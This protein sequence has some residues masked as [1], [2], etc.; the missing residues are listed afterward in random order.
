MA[1]EPYY[2][3]RS[4]GALFIFFSWILHELYIKPRSPCSPGSL[5]L[6]LFSLAFPVFFLPVLSSFSTSPF[7]HSSFHETSSSPSIQPI[8]DRLAPGE[9]PSPPTLAGALYLEIIGCDILC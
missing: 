9:Q 1:C 8:Q 2:L 6:D 5:T 3:P 4:P 7:I